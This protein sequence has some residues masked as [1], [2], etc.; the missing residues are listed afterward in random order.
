MHQGCVCARAPFLDGSFDGSMY[1]VFV[2]SEGGDVVEC[3]QTRPQ[4]QAGRYTEKT[5][6]ALGKGFFANVSI[7][8]ELDPVKCTLLAIDK[9]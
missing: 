9:Y 3:R 2:V 1:P 4:T 8:Q 6:C 5:T 7:S